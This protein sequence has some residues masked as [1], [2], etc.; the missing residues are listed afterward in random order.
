MSEKNVLMEKIAGHGGDIALIMLNRAKALNALNE[1]MCKEI[2]EKILEWNNDPSIKA[3]VLKGAGDRA[4]C[5]GG[6]VRKIYDLRDKKLSD[7]QSFFK[8]EYK[9][10]HA[11]AHCQKPVIA[12]LNGVTM[13]GGVGISWP[14]MFRIATEKLMFA[15]PETT[16]GFYPDVAGGYYLS[17]CDQA[18]GR[19]LA[20][21][22]AHVG[23]AD[24]CLIGFA[25]H[26]VASESLD[27]ILQ[28]LCDTVFAANDPKRIAD[29]IN[30]YVKPLEGGALLA[31]YP[32]LRE[33]FRHETVEEIMQALEEDSNKE[34][35]KVAEV[36][37]S[38]SPTS[39]KVTL[40][41]L[42]RYKK[43]NYDECLQMDYRISTHFLEHNDFYEGVRALL[44]DKDKKPQWQPSELSQITDNMV[45]EYFAPIADELIF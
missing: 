16:I 22:G 25:T 3:V 29:I 39:L 21:S 35:K 6:D 12:F 30:P 27:N 17:R 36:L 37:A 5:A 2:F 45:A 34:M 7:K 33:C 41:Q 23:A 40:E 4:F 13:G 10:D 19:Y 9:L 18:Y 32:S 43:L 24:A 31:Q 14:A 20:L 11:I 38:K 8:N 42:K 44:V 26:Y 15:M 1:E 28:K